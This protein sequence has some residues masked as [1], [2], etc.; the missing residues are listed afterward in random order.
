MNRQAETV[1]GKNEWKQPEI[2]CT[3]V[4][5][6]SFLNE[7]IDKG[8]TIDYDC[9]NLWDRMGSKAFIELVKYLQK[10]YNKSLT[11]DKMSKDE[12]EH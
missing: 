3:V 8:K 4:C 11:E 9:Y 6:G 12:V 1:A 10:R 2:P 5:G 7:R